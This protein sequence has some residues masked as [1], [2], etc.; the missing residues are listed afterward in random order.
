MLRPVYGKACAVIGCIL[1]DKFNPEA[2]HTSNL[3]VRSDPALHY[4]L[5]V[6]VMLRN[7]A[8][9]V[10]PFPELE[11]YFADINNFPV[12]SR[13]FKPSEYLAGE[14]AGKREMPP[15]KSIHVSLQI[16]D[17]G[18]SAVNYRLEVSEKKPLS[19]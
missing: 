1:P 8:S 11:L 5:A 17:P 2:I 15:D 4:A 18:P 10:Q 6:D 19:Y 9:Y 12:A 16:V 7:T 13:S 14:L 3:V